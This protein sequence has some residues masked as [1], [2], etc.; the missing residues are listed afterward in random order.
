MGEADD[1]RL[2]LDDLG[3]VID[4]ASTLAPSAPDDLLEG[5]DAPTWGERL[6]A[7]GITPWLRRHRVVLAVGA[8]TVVAVGALGSA[9]TRSQ[10]PPVDPTIRA[11]VADALSDGLATQVPGV[12]YDGYTAVAVQVQ[13][14]AGEAITVLG[15]IGPGI[16][17]SRAVPDPAG[18]GVDDV[19]LAPGCDDPRSSTP[20]FDDY[21]LQ[22][23]RPVVRH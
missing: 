18:A 17:A 7:R 11:T 5:N 20:T 4:H 22:V 23:R 1:G 12:V 3:S 21:R 10:P 13:P 6:E 16:R 19:F 8:V 14:A 2:E 9:W 15:I